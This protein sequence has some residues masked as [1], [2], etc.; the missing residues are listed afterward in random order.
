MT[1][2]NLEEFYRRDMSNKK[3][4]IRNKNKYE[5]NMLSVRL[6]SDLA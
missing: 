4:A 6:L 3:S 2:C 5:I 1:P